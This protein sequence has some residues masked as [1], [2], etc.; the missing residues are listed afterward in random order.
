MERHGLD[1]PRSGCGKLEGACDCSDELAISIKC[2]E[3][4][5]Y[6]RNCQLLKNDSAARIF[7]LFIYLFMHL[8]NKDRNLILPHN[9][10]F[11]IPVLP[12]FIRQCSRE[13]ASILWRDAKVLRWAGLNQHSKI[14]RRSSHFMLPRPC[15]LGFSSNNLTSAHPTNSLTF[16]RAEQPIADHG[17]RQVMT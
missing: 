12:T 3:F 10:C 4:L 15:W 6:L 13:F 1:W 7:Y 16:T 5:D 17:L 14:S 2:V 11:H 8:A 9:K